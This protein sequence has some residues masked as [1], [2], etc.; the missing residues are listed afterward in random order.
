MM[1]V[2]VDQLAD[3]WINEKMYSQE[4]TTREESGESATDIVLH[5]PYESTEAAWAFV[6]Q[7]FAK[8]TSTKILGILGAG[9]LEEL[10]AV[11]SANAVANLRALMGRYPIMADVLHGV[12]QGDTP[13]RVWQEV[14]AL[15]RAIRDQSE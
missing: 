12:W 13:D 9:M 6:E 2:N 14:V 10:I 3:Q 4:A 8:T 7:V 5:L 1:E 15:R 11:D